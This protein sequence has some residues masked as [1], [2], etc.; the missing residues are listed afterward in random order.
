[1]PNR[2]AGFSPKKDDNCCELILQEHGRPTKK[3]VN[4]LEHLV[5]I[6]CYLPATMTSLQQ[7]GCTMP[8]SSTRLTG[9]QWIYR[10][11]VIF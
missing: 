3:W 8:R 7:N 2:I 5:Q 9:N 10:Q 1:L 4:L 11:G 6:S